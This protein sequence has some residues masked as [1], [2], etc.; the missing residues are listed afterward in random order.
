MQMTPLAG[1]LDAQDAPL[2][3][4]SALSQ[5][6][7][8]SPQLTAAWQK[9]RHDQITVQRERAEPIPNLTAQATV[10]QNTEVGQTVAGVSIGLPLPLYNRNQGTVQQ[11]QADLRRANAEVSRLELQLMTELAARHSD[12]LS[13]WQHVQEY[14]QSML[15]KSRT[16]VEKLEQMYQARRAPWLTV[17]AAKRT[18][19]ELEMEQ[20]NN[21][22]A[23]RTADIT[24]RGYLLMGGLTEPDGPI[25]GGHIDAVNQPR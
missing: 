15:P 5:M 11:A 22:L 8:S 21:Q 10:G 12:Y 4:D 23:Y 7:A 1:S 9:I 19:L 3:W 6:M 14:E 18:L 13:A 24:I 2:D 17:L 20:I 25:G 16:A